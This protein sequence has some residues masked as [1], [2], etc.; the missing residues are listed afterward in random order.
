MQ[1]HEAERGDH[2]HLADTGAVHVP[3]QDRPDQQARGEDRGQPGMDQAQLLEVA[4]RTAAP[5]HLDL[6]PLAEAATLAMG[7][8]EGAHQ[9][10]VVDDVEQ[11]AVHACR[12]AGIA[13]VQRPAVG[14]EP[15]HQPGEQR[16]QHHQHAGHQRADDDHQQDREAHV[17]AGRQH[18]PEGQVLQREHRH[19]GG[20]DAPCQRARHAVGEIGR[21]VAGQV[22]EQVA[23]QVAGD[24]DEGVGRDPAADS[25]RHVVE[26]DQP[27]E[28]AD[29]AP[30]RRH[31]TVAVRVQRVDQVVDRVRGSDRAADREDHRQQDRRVLD[32][33]APDVAEHERQR[34]RRQADQVG[35]GDGHL[36]VDAL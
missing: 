35:V 12:L 15:E 20:R 8:P 25:P 24:G 6:H 1:D 29:R 4:Q 5:A 27:A 36:L 16:R 18:V 28:E 22:P 21:G 23:T 3:Q 11:F 34:A 30:D 31:R 13:M 32:L 9:R 26:R 17:Q 19:R 2:D 33:M 10:H 14:R 7:R